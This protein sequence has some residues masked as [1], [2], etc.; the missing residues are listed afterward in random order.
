MAVRFTRTPAAVGAAATWRDPRLWLGVV[1]VVGSV[2]AANAYTHRLGHRTTVY[3]AAHRIAA[4]TE[5][6]ESDLR[7]V[8]VALPDGVSAV[9]DA[10]ELLGMATTHDLAD[11]DILMASTVSDF[12]DG[13]TRTVSVPVRAGH[14][15]ALAHGSQVEVWLTP[16][17]QGTDAP[18]PARLI[19]EVATVIAA[20]ESPDAVSDTAVSLL[21][22]DTEV[23]DLVQA[24]RDGTVDVV[25]I[26]QST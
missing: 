20:P 9:A 15:P 11:G 24:M 14:L 12:R 23:G 4:G 1:L 2:V 17:L 6:T 21:V 19:I 3:A 25:L 18:G 8:S 16:S 7:A 10:A 22:S 5:L 26:G 13:R